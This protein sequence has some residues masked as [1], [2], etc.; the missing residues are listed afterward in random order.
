M[1]ARAT[2]CQ[3]K[4]APHKTLFHGPECG[5]YCSGSVLH[6]TDPLLGDE[7]SQESHAGCE[8]QAVT[9]DRGSLAGIVTPQIQVV[10]LHGQPEGSGVGLQNAVHFNHYSSQLAMRRRPSAY[11]T[12]LTDPAP[13][14]Q[15]WGWPCLSMA[16]AGCLATQ[17]L[18]LRPDRRG[19][20]PTRNLPFAAQGR[21][22]QMRA[23]RT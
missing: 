23:S 8:R 5:P 11:A 16:S 19:R 12:W 22:L 3:A 17:T 2:D 9:V 13:S 1:K 6:C 14:T 15:L 7:R 4:G 21:E 10:K 18:L 20:P